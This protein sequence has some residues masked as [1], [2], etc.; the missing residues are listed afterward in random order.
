[1]KKILSY[2]QKIDNINKV[3]ILVYLGVIIAFIIETF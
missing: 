3:S 1:M 2:Y